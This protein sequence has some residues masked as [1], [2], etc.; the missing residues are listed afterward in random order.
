MYLYIGGDTALE[1]DRIIGIFDLDNTSWSHMTRKYLSLAEQAGHIKNTAEDIP[2][3]F[4]VCS[5]ETVLLTQPSTA[6]LV[7]RL[8]N[9]ERSNV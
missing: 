9:Q 4:V 2:R 1:E 3:S 8:E 5:D 7:R 6:T